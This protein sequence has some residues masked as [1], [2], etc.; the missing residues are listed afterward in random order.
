M[1][2]SCADQNREISPSD[3]YNLS[4]KELAATISSAKRGDIEAMNRLFQ[5]YAIANSEDAKGLYWLEQAAL[6]GDKDAQQDVVCIYTSM[7]H[8][9]NI[10][11]RG[12]QLAKQFG[13]S[14]DCSN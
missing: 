5:F 14:A 11:T 8:D 13:V 3:S 1:L 4:D 2:S 9:K 6:H 7:Q 10:T 12:Q